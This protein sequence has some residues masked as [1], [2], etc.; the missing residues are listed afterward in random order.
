MADFAG[1]VGVVGAGTMGTGIAIT[2][3]RAGIPTVLTDV[4]ETQLRAGADSVAAFLNKSVA[5]GKLTAQDRAAALDRLTTA[6]TFD[7]LADCAVVIE[8]IAEDVAAKQELFATL[9]KTVGD[10]VL[11]VTNTSTLSVTAIAAGAARPENVVGMHFC[12]PAPL[13]PLVEVV[14]GMRT[15][16]E[17]HAAALRLTAA[18]G[19][20]AVVIKDTPGFIV[21]RL[22]I[23]FENDCIRALERGVATVADIDRAVRFGLGYPMGPFTLLDTVGLDLH[24]AVSLSL[25][26]QLRDPRF[27]P[28]PLVDRMIAAGRL[29]RKTGHGFYEYESAGLFGT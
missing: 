20:T 7:G 16:A 12:N 2:A 21:N 5:R 3:V 8:A 4:S 24:R 23:P 13:M 9:G 6:P 27:A 25:Y 22:L 19:K 18:L 17:T 11:L 14:D 26:H 28:P 15:S 1:P 10:E 29:G